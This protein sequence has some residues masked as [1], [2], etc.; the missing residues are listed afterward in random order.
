MIGLAKFHITGGG[1][2]LTLVDII[3]LLLVLDPFPSNETDRG[4]GVLTISTTVHSF[5]L[6][7]IKREV[8]GF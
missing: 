6:A 3:R 7:S 2:V 1:N 8:I 4:W 5:P